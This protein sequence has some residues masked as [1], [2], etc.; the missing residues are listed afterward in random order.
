[1]YTI[2]PDV[3]FSRRLRMHHI[4]D[5]DD[6]VI[7]SGKNLVGA[8]DYLIENAIHEVKIDGGTVDMG[9]IVQFTRG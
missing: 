3:Y 1:V 6:E 7:W 5:D 9:F 8:L 4:V 2:H